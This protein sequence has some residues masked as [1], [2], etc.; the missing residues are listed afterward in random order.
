MVLGQKNNCRGEKL[1]SSE[2][3]EYSTLYQNN[4][5]KPLGNTEYFA[6][7]RESPEYS[8][9]NTDPDDSYYS[10]LKQ[11]DYQYITEVQ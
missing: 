8:S 1:L 5:S 2:S 3:E 4:M 11:P 7:K 9:L 10:S 6:L